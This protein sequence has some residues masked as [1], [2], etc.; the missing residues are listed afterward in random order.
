MRDMAMPHRYANERERRHRPH[1]FRNAPSNA[2]VLYT[3]TP[4]HVQSVSGIGQRVSGIGQPV[5]IPIYTD[6]PQSGGGWVVHVR[7]A[8]QLVVLTLKKRYVSDVSDPMPVGM[9]CEREPACG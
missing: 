8:R 4:T 9:L 3:Y 7:Q 2:V 1:V 5:D 6:K